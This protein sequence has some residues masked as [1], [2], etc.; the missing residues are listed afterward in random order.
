M[1]I[2]LAVLFGSVLSDT[3]PDPLQ[4]LSVGGVLRRLY[5]NSH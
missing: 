3:G 4:S 2:G 1:C 5:E